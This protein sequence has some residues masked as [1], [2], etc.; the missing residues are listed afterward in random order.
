VPGG[1]PFRLPAHEY[2]GP[3]RYFLT[4]CTE[5]RRPFFIDMR[6]GG[7]SRDAL[8]STATRYG[9][10]VVAYCFMPDHL[11]ALLEGQTAGAD[12]RKFVVMYKQQSAFA[13]RRPE[14]PAA[15]VTGVAATL[16]RSRCAR[17]WQRSYYEHVLRREEDVPAVVAYV[18][19]NPG[20]AGLCA[21]PEEYPLLG[22]DRYSIRELADAA[23]A[24]HPP[25]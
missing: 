15:T 2:R 6:I 8:L 1:H 10:A 9:F 13:F 25:A 3:R 18:L 16:S 14:R 4:I 5:H 20:R 7:A 24:D 23:L 22:S 21:S 11:H 19:G 12:F 17:L